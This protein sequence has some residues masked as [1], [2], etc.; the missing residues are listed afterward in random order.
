MK[1]QLTPTLYLTGKY[2]QVYLK[3]F[4]VSGLNLALNAG[5][6]LRT[7]T[8]FPNANY[9]VGCHAKEKTPTA[10]LL[11]CT[12][13]FIQEFESESTWIIDGEEVKHIVKYI[14][15]DEKFD[16]ISDQMIYWGATDRLET[17]IPK[18]YTNMPIKEIQPK[19]EYRT[20]ILSRSSNDKMDE[21]NCITERKDSL[22]LPTLEQIRFENCQYR[23]YPREHFKTS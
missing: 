14:V 5:T 1:I 10:G 19:M 6:D 2:P 13:S 16:A 7:N 20:P 11:I 23:Y 21:N 4:E 12:Q 17:R 8:P 15:I 3:K 18:A 22:L 9:Y